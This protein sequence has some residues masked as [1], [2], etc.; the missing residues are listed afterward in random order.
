MTH[1]IRPSPIAEIRDV[2]APLLRA[3]WEEVAKNKHLMVLD[4]DWR[5]YEHLEAAGRLSSF[6]AWFDGKLVGYSVSIFFPK[7][8][9][10]SGL[11]V[12]Q[13]DVIY[14]A[15]ECRGAKLE[16]TG[17]GLGRELVDA[18]LADAKQRGARL[19]LMHAKPGTALD[20]CLPK[21]GFAVQDIIYSIEV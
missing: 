12:M 6:S 11:A 19:V 15:P 21:W 17:R 14:V 10:Y 3:H 9:H 5:Y 2:A 13:N 8:P 20:R 16:G 4:P 7:H 18:T 1:R